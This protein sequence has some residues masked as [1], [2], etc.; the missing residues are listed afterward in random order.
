MD[1]TPKIG[2]KDA[3]LK[4]LSSR[5]RSEKEIEKRL[6][7][8]GFRQDNIEETISFLKER[9]YINDEKF[10]YQWAKYRI[11][12]RSYGLMRISYELK[13]KGVEKISIESIINTLR[14]EFDEREVA[15]IAAQ[16]K[17]RGMEKSQSAL[18]KI[19]GY[20]MRKGFSSPIVIDVM[21]KIE[22]D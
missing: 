12:N 6:G 11:E 2:A 20:L 7:E 14:D 22:W 5:W 16:R 3:A 1:E 13:G 8:K 4:I 18:K 17:V 21:D 15:M 19:Y 10:G 9:G